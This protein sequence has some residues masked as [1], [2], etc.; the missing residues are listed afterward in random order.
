MLQKGGP[1]RIVEKNAGGNSI[2]CQISSDDDRIPSE[3]C[4]LVIHQ[5]HS[6]AFNKI[7]ALLASREDDLS[8]TALSVLLRKRASLVFH[9]PK[10]AASQESILPLKSEVHA[11]FF[12]CSLFSYGTSKMR[13]LCVTKIFT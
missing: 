11:L 7:H 6:K 4:A 2:C 10:K 3:D 12:P 13:L 5:G 9:V 8:Q 1:E